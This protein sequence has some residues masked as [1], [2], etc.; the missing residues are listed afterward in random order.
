MSSTERPLEWV[1]THT[2]LFTSDFDQD[3]GETVARAVEAGVGLL[4]LA[5]I[6]EH[7]IGRMDEMLGTYECCVGSLGI[8]PTDVTEDWR[9]QMRVVERAYARGGRYVAVG[10]VGLDLYWDKS[11]F[12]EQVAAF[13]YELEWA[14]EIGKPVLIHARNAI[15]EV[16]DILRNA[17]FDE[18]PVV[19]HAYNGGME[20]WRDAMALPA[21]WLGIGGIATY[22]NGL[23]HELIKSLDLRRTLLETDSP[24]LPP[25][26][27]RG[28]RNESA[29]VPFVGEHL[30]QVRGESVAHIAE[31]T[32]AS[33]KRFLSL[34]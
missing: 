1:D 12:R 17:P 23:S 2:H 5:N 25:T 16:L 24:Y 9:K 6:D 29:Y 27:H 34:S 20:E 7:S 28:R 33:A 21:V 8:H 30:A 15:R 3:R 11:L 14:R 4:V 18:I 22:K 10:E 19:L 26:P 31:M 13:T 32:T